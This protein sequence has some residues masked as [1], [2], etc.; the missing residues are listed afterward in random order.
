V[1]PS[2]PRI[3]FAAF[4]GGVSERD[5]PG[6]V[7]SLREGLRRVADVV[8]IAIHPSNPGQPTLLG[9]SRGARCDA[10]LLIDFVA[11]VPEPFFVY[12]TSQEPP[13]VA[14][15]AAY[16][17][18]SGLFAESDWRARSLARTWGISREKIHVVPPALVWRQNGQKRGPVRIRQVPR[19]KLLYI[20]GK[21]RGRCSLLADQVILDAFRILRR[22]YDPCVSLTIAGTE[23][24]PFPGSPPA[25]VNF[26][27]AASPDVASKLIDSHDLFVMPSSLEPFGLAFADALSRGVPC[28]IPGTCEMFGA[29]T[30]GIS[31]AFVDEGDAREL[32]SAIASTLADDEMYHTCYE[33]APAMAAY[34][35]WERVARQIT[36]VISR[37]VGLMAG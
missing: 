19:R 18:A 27:G 37:E 14:D 7:W 36:Q 26:R 13:T 16:Q 12:S 4:Q 31:G 28:V 35:S 2:R 9:T 17:R 20:C 23:E 25:G 3:G 33:R 29:I 22:E 30:P 15:S 8:D 10:V 34:F 21:R 11:P 32:A 6:S 5:W 24:W 1:D